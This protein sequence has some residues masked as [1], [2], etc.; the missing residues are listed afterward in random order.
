M[1]ALAKNALLLSLLLVV[2]A[3]ADAQTA[4]VDKIT[5]VD[6]GIYHLNGVNTD[7]GF[8]PVADVRRAQVSLLSQTHDIPAKIGTKFGFRFQLSGT[9]TDKEAHIKHIVFYPPPGMKDPSLPQPRTQGVY[10]TDLMIGITHTRLFSFD[11]DWE[12][13]PGVWTFQ[14]FNDDKMIAEQKFTVVATQ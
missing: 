2:A 4:K 14:V 13:V 9:P 8:V 12:M 11:K 6:F 1:K 3:S 10:E 5:I 7:K